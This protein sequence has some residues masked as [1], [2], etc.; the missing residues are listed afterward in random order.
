MNR[1][2]RIFI[3]SIPKSWCAV[4]GAS[5]HRQRGTHYLQGRGQTLCA[6]IFKARAARIL[7]GLSRPTRHSLRSK[8]ASVRIFEIEPSPCSYRLTIRTV[9]AGP[10][11]CPSH[12]SLSG[13]SVHGLG[14]SIRPTSP[15]CCSGGSIARF[16]SARQC[17]GDFGVTIGLGYRAAGH[18]AAKMQRSGRGTHQVQRYGDQLFASGLAVW[19]RI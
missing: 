11:R 10:G 3:H 13:H 9:M 19:T 17:H 4:A 18:I 6:F 7:G 8:Q 1:I 16:A 14:G 12:D 5:Q 15:G 2:R